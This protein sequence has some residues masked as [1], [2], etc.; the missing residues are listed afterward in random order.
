MPS[1]DNLNIVISASSKNANASLNELIKTLKNLKREFN[2]NA[3]SG[4]K[5]AK[6]FTEIEKS[7]NRTQKSFKGMASAFGK[8]YA[9]YFLLIRGVKAFGRAITSTSDYLETLNFYQVALNKIGKEGEQ[10]EGT[11]NKLSGLKIELFEDGTGQIINTGVKNLGLNLEEV[12]QYMAKLL[13]V[14]NSLGLSAEI[15]EASADA[16][17][18]LAGDMSSLFN[19]DYSSAATNLQSG[20]TGQARAL[21]KYGIDITN[22]TLQTYAYEMGLNKMVSEMTQ[23]EKMQLRMLAILDQSKVAWGDLARTIDSPSN[24]I[25][26]FKNNVSELAI[27]VGQLFI[28]IMQKVMPVVNGVTIALKNLMTTIAGF[29][30]VKLD[31]ADAAQGFSDLSE[32][33]LGLEDSLDGVAEAAKK[34]NQQLAKYDELNVI[35]KKDTGSGVGGVGGGID[36]TQQILDATEEYNKAW[37]DAYAQM[38]SR[39]QQFADKISNILEPVKRLFQNIS[40]GNW[41]GAGQDVSSIVSGILNTFSE[42]IASVPWYEVGRNIG[43]FLA[44]IKWK[45]IIGSIGKLIWEAINAGIDL[46]KGMFDAAPIETAILTGV[47]LLSFTPLGTIIATKLATAL[48]K[49]FKGLKGISLFDAKTIMGAG[50]LAEKFAFMFKILGSISITIG[51]LVGSVKSFLNMWNEGFSRANQ[52]LMVLGV[53][54]T[55]IGAVVLGAPAT[56]ALAIGGIV[57][58]IGTLTIALKDNRDKIDAAWKQ[59]WTNVYNYWKPVVDDIK[60]LTNGLVEWIKNSA[61]AMMT[62]SFRGFA[63]STDKIFVDLKNSIKQTW[64]DIVTWFKKNVI[65]PITKAFDSIGNG[66]KNKVNSISVGSA[67]RNVTGFATGGFP[68]KGDLFIANEAG[69]EL[70]GSMGGRTAVANNDQITSGIRDAAYMGMKQALSETGGNGVNV[71]IEGEMR[72]LFKA[73]IKENNAYRKQTGYSM[74]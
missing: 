67:V 8:F 37:E 3:N 43:D 55:G 19:I 48:K 73:F 13:S 66:I 68:T 15:S 22:A 49:G 7:T 11:L 47:G 17:A 52:A 30:G 72:N 26:Q 63:T 36:L 6:G 61:I 56:V 60:I 50:T 27:T 70:V 29:F 34:A 14:T 57:S 1:V 39:A 51:G 25:R 33:V 69:P 45:E 5:V 62:S 38:E 40:L 2:I 10:L 28:P 53:T 58:A 65:E 32:D 59:L 31:L 74:F 9:N 23:A 12:T 24:L 46:W 16:F 71:V 54:L 64:Q 18:K 20:L 4:I 42:A 44:G 21:Y 35:S 41:F